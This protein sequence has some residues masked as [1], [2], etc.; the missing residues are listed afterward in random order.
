MLSKDARPDGYCLD[1]VQSRAPTYAS[2]LALVKEP[3]AT[4][5]MAHGHLAHQSDAWL[6]AYADSLAQYDSVSQGCS[7]WPSDQEKECYDRCIEHG[8]G[9]RMRWQTSLRGM[10]RTGEVMA[11]KLSGAPCCTPS[12]LPDIL[13]CHV[14]I[15]ME[16]M[17]VVAFI[18]HQG[19]VN[20]W[21]LLQLARDLLQW[22]DW[23]LL[24]MRAVHVPRHVGEHQRRTLTALC[25]IHWHTL[26]WEWM[27]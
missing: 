5:R 9:S 3:G 10:V 20:S 12:F 4:E 7:Y 11:H 2:A 13:H 1:S 18:N 22:A 6:F 25:F 19:G 8:V 26:P 14:L 16:S 17:T 15:R 24:S 23:H 27:H 21:P